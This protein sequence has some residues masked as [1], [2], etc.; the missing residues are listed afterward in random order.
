[1]GLTEKYRPRTFDEFVGNDE[2]IAKLKPFCRQ[3]D[4][5]PNSI[6]LIGPRGCGKTTLA[7]II[8]RELKVHDRDFFEMNT[9]NVRGIET[10]REIERKCQYAPLASKY[11]IYFFDECHKLT[12]DAQ[13]A[14]LK[15][16]EKPPKHIIFILA[17]TDPEL[18][19]DT[20]L[21]R[22][23]HFEVKLLDRKAIRGLIEDILFEE[24]IKKFPEEAIKQIV[25]LADG[26]PREAIVLLDIAV[27]QFREEGPDKLLDAIDKYSLNQVVVKD[28]CQA[29]L[30]RVP[31]KDI[32][33]ILKGVDGEAE[34][35]RYQVLGYM[36]TI[37]MN[38][39]NPQAAMI[40]E[41][42]SK[43]FMYNKKAGL[44]LACYYSFLGK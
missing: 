22:C 28:L 2:M 42:F 37:L 18:L 44:T 26:C 21:S 17:T 27:A 33:N 43:S 24:D 12:Q 30:K 1:M 31:W 3:P 5:P 14:F 8:K 9:G 20:I 10:I 32:G 36:N 25:H 29:L 35:I 15:P 23:G 38:T 41:N 39:D 34:Q 11:K 4:G 6:L 40:I 7:G 16:L 13:N 19:L